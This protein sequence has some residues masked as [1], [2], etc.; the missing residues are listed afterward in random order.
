[1]S[2]AQNEAAMTNYYGEMAALTTHVK[3]TMQ[4]TVDPDEIFELESVQTSDY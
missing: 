1:M 3:L 4:P 2:Y